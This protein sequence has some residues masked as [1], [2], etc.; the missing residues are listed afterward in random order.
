ML[1]LS[2]SNQKSADSCNF[3]ERDLINELTTMWTQH[4]TILLVW[5]EYIKCT[6]CL[7]VGLDPPHAVDGL[8]LLLL[9]VSRMGERRR[10][11]NIIVLIKVDLL[12]GH[13]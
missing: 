12:V 2:F 3:F 5:S 9:L 11:G 6:A 1:G 7:P 4:I 10:G 8:L 13:S